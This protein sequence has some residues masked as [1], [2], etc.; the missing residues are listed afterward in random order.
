MSVECRRTREGLPGGACLTTLEADASVT[1]AVVESR[2]PH[3]L[4]AHPAGGRRARRLFTHPE[5]SCVLARSA[6]VRCLVFPHRGGRRRR[7]TRGEAV[8]HRIPHPGT[9]ARTTP[10]SGP[11][12]TVSRHLEEHRMSFQ[13]DTLAIHAGQAPDP[14]TNARAVPIY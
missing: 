7:R 9:E 12:L 10:R 3:A 1:R 13:P 2:R 6:V 11:G 8:E 4:R 5:R 14:A